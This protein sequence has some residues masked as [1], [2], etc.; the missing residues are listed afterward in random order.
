VPTCHN[1]PADSDRYTSCRWETLAEAPERLSC[2]LELEAVNR[3]GLLS[4]ITSLVAKSQ[5]NIGG[6]SSSPGSDSTEATVHFTVEV[7]DLFVLADV[8]KRLEAVKGV[9]SVK[10]L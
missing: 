7:P 5:L 4:D 3:V 1:L 10:R 8:M 6:V 2:S 9:T